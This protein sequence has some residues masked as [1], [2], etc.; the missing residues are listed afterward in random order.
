LGR[1][2]FVARRYADAVE[3]FKRIGAPDAFHHAFLAACHAQLGDAVAAD[4]HAREVLRRIPGFSFGA[5]LLPI[6]YYKRDSDIAHH[7]ES[8]EK[9]G[10]PLGANGS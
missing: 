8:I 5:T 3:A 6:L 1:A 9:A 10:L 4:A 2:Y 7:R